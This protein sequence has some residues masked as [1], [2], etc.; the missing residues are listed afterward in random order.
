MRNS[1]AVQA[2]RVNRAWLA[3]VTSMALLLAGL[4]VAK[5]SFSDQIS[6]KPS[7]DLSPQQVI[8]IVVESLQNNAADDAGIATV[9][10]FASPGNKA[11]TGPLARFT[12]MIKRG[13]SD[14]LNHV[15]VRY[16]DMEMT[17]DVAVQA[18][19]LQTVTGAEYGYAFQLRKQK[20]GET[21]GM[22]MT[23][24]VIPLGQSA[25]SGIGI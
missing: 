17:G 15:G 2:S 19:W 23:E 9:Y 10:R 13:F 8:N 16:D 4:L 14:M 18:V 1:T 6:P 5:S 22:W 11:N 25:Q 21:D 3:T 24:G 12:Y 20:G 7:T